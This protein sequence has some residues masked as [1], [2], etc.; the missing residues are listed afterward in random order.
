MKIH[1]VKKGETLFNIAKKYGIEL[2]KLISFNNQLADPDNID[3]GMKIKIPSSG[4]AVPP[5]VG[6]ITHKH[7]VVQGDS[8][9]KLAKAWDIPLKA[10]IDANPHLKNPNVLMTGDI[11]YIPKLG[12]DTPHEAGNVES[13]QSAEQPQVIEMAE[14]TEGQP[15]NEEAPQWPG[16]SEAAE[17]SEAEE[18]SQPIVTEHE[19]AEFPFAQYQLP[20]MEAMNPFGL[21]SAH[22]APF[23]YDKGSAQPEPQPFPYAQGMAMSQPQPFPYAQG[24]AQSQPQPFPFAQGA[25][26]PQPNPFPF[27]QGM[28]QP[29]PYPAQFPWSYDNA[30]PVQQMPTSMSNNAFPFMN[31][32][33]AAPVMQLPASE[34]KSSGHMKSSGDISDWSAGQPTLHS[35]AQHMPTYPQQAYP[36]P[37]MSGGP[38]LPCQG[39]GQDYGYGSYPSGM[40]GVPYALPASAYPASHSPHSS[41][42]NKEDCG[43]DERTGDIGLA[44]VRGSEPVKQE[45][46]GEAKVSISTKTKPPKR[47][48][49]AAKRD[50]KQNSPWIRG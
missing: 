8:L 15:V 18:M 17:K 23:S 39:K 2:Q 37:Q 11:V 16:I 48:Q 50:K 33:P 28:G 29:Q 19:E 1:L 12:T 26:Q 41:W 44:S 14:A 6:D 36:Y 32:M 30:M 43:C 46:S 21:Q 20:A 25:A 9:W 24:M 4:V 38:C 34:Q 7:V 42:S 3:V 40:Y 5:P 35:P 27:A 22:A 45:K 13:A 49:P 47:K 31:A 10:V